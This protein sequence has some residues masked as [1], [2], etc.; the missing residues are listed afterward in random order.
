MVPVLTRMN[1][2]R[3]KNTVHP[4]DS[5]TVFVGFTNFRKS[6]RVWKVTDADTTKPVWADISGDLPKRC[7]VNYLQVDPKD[8]GRTMNNHRTGRQTTATFDLLMYRAP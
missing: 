4:G 6:P 8:P 5:G 2:V 1:K 7:P 3:F